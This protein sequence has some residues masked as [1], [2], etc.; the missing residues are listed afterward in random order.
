MEFAFGS[1]M[2]MAEIAEA[3][4]CNTAEVFSVMPVEGRYIAIHTPGVEEKKL[5]ECPGFATTLQRDKDGILR[6]VRGP[7]AIPNF[8]AKLQASI[9]KLMSEVRTGP[10]EDDDER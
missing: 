1:R 4:N 10:E 2:F 3:L 6:I 8:S 5:S 7:Q 9:S